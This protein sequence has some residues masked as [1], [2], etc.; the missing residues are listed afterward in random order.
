MA[1]AFDQNVMDS[2][3][4]NKFLFYKP[5]CKHNYGIKENSYK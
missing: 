1:C 3:V 4:L 2:A 5:I